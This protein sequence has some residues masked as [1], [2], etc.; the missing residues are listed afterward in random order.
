MRGYDVTGLN[1]VGLPLC[2]L[3]VLAV[4]ALG[5]KSAKRVEPPQ[6]W[7]PTN[8]DKVPEWAIV[9]TTTVIASSPHTY[10]S[11]TTH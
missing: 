10:Y 5:A 3:P 4:L 8:P 7:S 6:K 9:P 1:I 2:S 11:D